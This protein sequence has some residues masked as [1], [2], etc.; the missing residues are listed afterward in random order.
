VCFL[1]AA[2]CGI[3]TAKDIVGGIGA[4]LGEWSWQVSIQ[5]YDYNWRRFYHFC[6]GTVIASKWVVTAAHCM[7]K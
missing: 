7:I 4:Q 6:G 5:Y 2:L 3:K 1:F